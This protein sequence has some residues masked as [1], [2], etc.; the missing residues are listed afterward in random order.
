MAMDNVKKVSHCINIASS[1]TFKR[2]EKERLLEE[3]DSEHES[4]EGDEEEIDD[5]LDPFVRHFNYDLEENLLEAVS[6]L[7]KTVDKHQQHWPILGQFTVHIPKAKTKTLVSIPKVTIEEKRKFAKTG[8]VPQRITSVC[9]TQLHVKSQIQNNITKANFTNL[10]EI[11]T[12]NM[13]PLTPLQKELFSII[14]NYQD[15]YYPERTLKNG[16]EIRFTYCLHSINHILKT[17]TKILH[18]NNKLL[19]KYEVPEEYRDQGLVRPKVIILVPFREAALRVVKMMMEIILPDEK[20]N[21]MN[22]RRFFDEFTGNEIAMPKKK[23]RPE[24]YEETFVGNT[25]DTFRIGIT[26]TKKSIR[27][28]CITGLPYKCYGVRHISTV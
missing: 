20:A 4:A 14:N 24:D 19:N 2:Y 22:K 26:V 21:V 5:D 15:L 7:P 10:H 11:H 9:F 23:P 1:R 27:V 17:R 6:T 25:D 13:D 3:A 12:E 28:S 8:T 18:H 16:E